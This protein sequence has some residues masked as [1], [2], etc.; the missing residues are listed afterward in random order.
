[1]SFVEYV[2]IREGVLAPDR[3]P[4]AGLPRINVTG[5][6]NDQRRRLR[7][8]TVRPP[9]PVLRLPQVVPQEMVGKVT[10][11][12]PGGRVAGPSDHP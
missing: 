7:V 5:M 9:T 8:T 2:A 3:P 4:A 12:V 10:L 6:T 11:P 1:M